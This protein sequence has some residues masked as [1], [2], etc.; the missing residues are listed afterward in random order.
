MVNPHSAPVVVDAKIPQSDSTVYEC[1]ACKKTFSSKWNLNRHIEGTHEEKKVFECALCD[2][3]YS[4]KENLE[5]HIARY[6]NN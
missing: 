2:K 4:R 1:E 6:H 5:S 3:I